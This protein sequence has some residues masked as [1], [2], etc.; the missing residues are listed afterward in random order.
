[1]D[2]CRS[3]IFWTILQYHYFLT[4]GEHLRPQSPRT[5]LEGSPS[6]V[7]TVIPLLNNFA[8]DLPFH[9]SRLYNSAAA[10]CTCER[11]L[12]D[13]NVLANALSKSLIRNVSPEDNN[14][15]I[16]TV[17]LTE[18]SGWEDITCHYM[19]LNLESIDQL[20]TV[21][22]MVDVY[23]Y[24]RN[25]PTAKNSKWTVERKIIESNRLPSAY[26]TIMYSDTCSDI[27][28]S[29]G[30][31]TS[32]GIVESGEV[33]VFPPQHTT[34]AGSMSRLVIHLCRQKNIPVVFKEIKLSDSASWT[35]AFLTSCTKK[36]VA[37]NEIRLPSTIQ[38]TTSAEHSKSIMFS[39][40]DPIIR[41]LRSELFHWIH[42]SKDSDMSRRLLLS[43]CDDESLSSYPMWWPL[44]EEVA[45]LTNSSLLTATASSLFSV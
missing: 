2:Y 35:G 9:L 37:I 10:L 12:P 41:M 42:G 5:F 22:V 28:L 27:L 18:S 34:L 36:V 31:I 13:K 40:T 16:L 4:L 1:M 17:L 19:K 14:Y 21:S 23:P 38:A 45:T 33:V 32:F 24:L 43:T 7:Y 30:L 3:I 25:N 20:E 29:E 15:G 11:S 44:E 39:T 26:E 8:L 6:G